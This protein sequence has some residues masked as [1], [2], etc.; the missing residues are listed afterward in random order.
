MG[1]GS[2]PGSRPPAEEIARLQ[3]EL[4]RERAKTRALSDISSALGSTLDLDELLALLATRITEVLE[5]ERTVVY[6]LGEDGDSLV[7]RHGL[8]GA[9]PRRLRLGEGVA[10]WVA[11]TG[12]RVRL[13]DPHADARFDPTWDAHGGYVTTSTVAAP[14][15]NRHGRTLGVVQAL[16]R[17]GGGA[18]TDDDELLLSALATQAGVSLENGKLFISV[19][20]KNMELLDTKEQLEGR[21][22]ELNMLFEIAQVSAKATELDE[23]LEG[24]LQRALTAVEAEAGAILIEDSQG[25]LRYRSTVGLPSERLAQ[26]RIPKGQGIAGWVS[27]HDEPQVVNDVEGDSRH[28]RAVAER[29]GYHPRSILAVP[30]RWEGGR[31]ALEVFDKFGGEAPFTEEDVRA[32]TLVATHI[33]TAIGLARTRQRRGRAERLSTIGQLLS[34]VIH[35]LKTPMTVVSG[36]VRLLVDEED[37]EERRMMAGKITKQV[38]VINAMTRELL[39]FARGDRSVWI[40]K[41]YLKPFFN[42]LKEQL[43]QEFSSRGIEVRLDMQDRGTAR[44]DEHKIR[45]AVT[46]LA[47]N[48]AEAIGEGIGD[49]HGVFEITV[50]RRSDRALVLAFR[51]DGPGISPEIQAELFES[52]TSHGKRGGT[53]LGLA[54]VQKV[55]DD[56]D[57][58]VYVESEPGRTVFTL[59]LP[60]LDMASGIHE[61]AK[62][63]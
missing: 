31:G 41:V 39:A 5:A 32:A 51:D 4:A 27:Q 10:G 18:F 22:R 48:A 15:K 62:A 38:E 46:N 23:L 35:D 13:D 37:I 16:N 28:L 44:F 50:A 33:S 61:R 53:G 3:R 17:R 20:S 12:E 57:G 9:E 6:L 19:I 55:V 54:I 21:V 24:V 2:S 59:V 30:L 49:G 45:R 42:E 7:A 25:D 1:M 47:R 8:D 11:Q 58:E 34:S 60:Q 29:V 40:R 36:Y 52:F 26:Q 56:H 43:A 63:S 14:M